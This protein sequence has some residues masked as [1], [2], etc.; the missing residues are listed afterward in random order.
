[1]E[2]RLLKIEEERVKAEQQKKKQQEALRNAASL[3][4]MQDKIK[5]DQE[6]KAQT[7]KVRTRSDSY[8]APHEPF[9][10]FH[11]VCI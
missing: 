10:Y 2:E 9:S 5:T 4:C 11:T 1:M 3:Q 7:I 8:E 6:K